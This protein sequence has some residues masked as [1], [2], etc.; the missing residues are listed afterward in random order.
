MQ[1]NCSVGGLIDRKVINI[2]TIF[3]IGAKPT[4]FCARIGPAHSRFWASPNTGA[5]SQ[6]SEFGDKRAKMASLYPQVPVEARRDSAKFFKRAHFA[7][8][9]AAKTV[10][11]FP[12]RPLIL[13]ATKGM[14][15]PGQ[16]TRRKRRVDFNSRAFC[17][18]RTI[19]RALLILIR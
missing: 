11:L 7:R 5:R 2:I 14:L 1:K 10:T 3:N 16:D 18:A 9:G 13:I 6:N 4:R 8:Y 12:C 19:R 15:F 17:R